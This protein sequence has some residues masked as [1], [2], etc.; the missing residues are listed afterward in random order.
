M[1]SVARTHGR[2]AQNQ[3][4]GFEKVLEC[5]SYKRYCWTTSNCCAKS[6][7]RAWTTK[8]QAAAKALRALPFLPV[9]ATFASL[10]NKLT[11]RLRILSGSNTRS[12]LQR[13]PSDWLTSPREFFTRAFLRWLKETA[14]TS[15][16]TRSASRR[17]SVCS[18]KSS[19]GGGRTKSGWLSDLSLLAGMKG[20]GRLPT[21]T[22]S[23]RRRNS[24]FQS[25]RATTQPARSAPGKPGRGPRACAE[26][27]S[28]YLGPSEQRAIALQ[29]SDT[30]LDREE[31]EGVTLRPV[32]P[33]IRR[34]ALDAGANI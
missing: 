33:E 30:L 28:L 2:I 17:P 3:R 25:K 1:T 9:R 6:V 14:V 8:S 24:R 21:A 18:R 4:Q 16:T 20:H 29:Q 19:H 31:S 5:E 32:M 22:S 23:T 13:R 26:N 15:N 27:H 12:S 10:H 7:R 34:I 11:P